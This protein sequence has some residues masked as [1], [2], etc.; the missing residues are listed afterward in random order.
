M[1]HWNHRVIKEVLSDGTEWYSIR[2]V[3]YNDKE[4]E[5]IFGYTEKPV[6]IC[7][8]SIDEIRKYLQWCLGCLDKPILED[9]KVKFEDN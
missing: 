6:D 1:T 4:E 8:E 2:E 3:F 5:S 9:G 7:G